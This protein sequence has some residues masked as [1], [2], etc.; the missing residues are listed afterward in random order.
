MVTADSDG[1]PLA[2][3]IERLVRYEP[4]F[5]ELKAMGQR[6]IVFIS[7]ASIVLLFASQT[8]AETRAKPPISRAAKF[9][10]DCRSATRTGNIEPTTRQIQI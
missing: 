7:F 4:R 8:T 10:A 9:Q 2:E 3:A 1:H 5:R 6:F